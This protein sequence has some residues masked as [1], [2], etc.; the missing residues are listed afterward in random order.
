MGRPGSFFDEFEP[1]YSDEELEQMALD[2]EAER[3]ASL[4]DDE[5]AEL[6]EPDEVP[7]RDFSG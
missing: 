5:R 3:W 4:T 1:M 7:V 6:D 2:D